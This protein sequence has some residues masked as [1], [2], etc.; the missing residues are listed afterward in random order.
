[1]IQPVLKSRP[2][3]GNSQGSCV[4]GEL[5]ED[6]VDIMVH[7]SVLEQILDYSERDLTRELGGFLL[8][9]YYLDKTPYV[10]VRHFLEA[11][12]VRSGAASLTFTHETWSA[13]TREVADQ[14]P[15]ELIVGWY[16]THPQ[17]QVFLSGYDL[18]IHRHFFK[19][20]WQVAMVVDPVLQ[21]FGF[22]QWHN[23]RV[24][25]CGFTC[26]RKRDD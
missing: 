7:E 24:I 25:D 4:L 11:V 3:D 14:F 22:F 23:D 13:M 20:P 21:E 5:R 19:E 15:G 2:V 1:M 17:L 8:G 10:E 6:A 16:H 9:G 26:V 12:D 18:F